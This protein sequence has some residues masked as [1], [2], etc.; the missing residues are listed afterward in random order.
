MKKI[1]L[2][3]TLIIAANSHVLAAK[4]RGGQSSKSDAE[5]S[6]QITSV[7]INSAS[8]EELAKVLKGIGMKKAEAIIAYRE[9]FG[10]FKSANELTAVK[11]IGE[12]TVEKNRSKIKL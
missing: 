10:P 8:A 11:G 4:E 1:A 6:Q 2:F 9:K 7:N 5:L 3:L 12:K